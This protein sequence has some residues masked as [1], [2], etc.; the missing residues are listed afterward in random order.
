MLQIKKLSNS[1]KATYKLQTIFR[2]NDLKKKYSLK[3]KISNSVILRSP[4]HFNIGKQKIKSI[5]YIF[6][7]IGFVVKKN[8]YSN[9]IQ[10]DTKYLFK[11]LDK[12][13]ETN[14]YIKTDSVKLSIKTKFIIMWL[15]F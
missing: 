12:F 3:K 15:E 7:N 10:Q 1:L 4:K 5:N 9:I 8:V 2:L 11:L 14:I 13:T 6:V